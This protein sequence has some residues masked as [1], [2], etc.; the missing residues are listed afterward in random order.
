MEFTPHIK[1]LIKG[2]I[3]RHRLR[4]LIIAAASF[5]ALFTLVGFLIL[6]I[7]FKSILLKQ[8]SETLHGEV[9]I[10][11]VRVN[12][13]VLSLT[14][15]GLA[16]KDPKSPETLVS[17]DE[18]YINLQAKSAFK[19]ALILKEL[20]IK[21]PY[22]YVSRDKEGNINLL[23][24]LPDEETQKAPP[25]NDRNTKALT[26]E[27]DNIQLTG[28]K[29]LFSDFLKHS[30]F[31]TTVDSDLSINNFS[32]SKNKESTFV[33]TIKTEAN[34]TAKIDGKFSLDP[35]SSEGTFDLKKISLSKYSPYYRDSV[36]FDIKDGDLD[37]LANYTYKEKE[38]KI[39]LLLA[40]LISLQLKTR[41][42]KEEFLEI[43]IA[44]VKETEIDILKKQITLG[45]LTTKGGN[46]IVNRLQDGKLNLE[47]LVPASS[48]MEVKSEQNGNRQD[49]TPWCLTLKD[50]VAE[51]YTVKFQD[52]I[53][54]EPVAISMERIKL[55][56]QN[57]S[58]VEN[59]QGRVFLSL[60]LNKKG[61]VSAEGP[62]GINPVFAD[63][64]VNLKDIQMQPFEP[65]LREE[66]AIIVKE[67][68]ISTTSNLSL[69]YSETDGLKAT[70]QG[71]ASISNFSSMD[72]SKGN[73]F[74]K[75]ESLHLG[76]IDFGYNPS[77]LKI[78]EVA[79]TNFYSRLVINP[80]ATINILDIFEKDGQLKEE[81][82]EEM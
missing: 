64:K 39:S 35:L 71:E 8:L 63:V 66:V 78:N 82:Q 43:P 51:Q 58:T 67:G 69:S 6:P 34:E 81:N 30:E 18:T 46:L 62:F 33:L 15:K 32:T 7:I 49:T 29:V 25:E 36:L 60:R 16:I 72:K 13:Y 80:D 76:D 59:S 27:V 79:I 19:R 40:S 20:N 56:T 55:Q 77:Y 23:S 53:L 44:S 75:W 65:Y 12:P 41:N 1:S 2:L 21:H 10:E 3:E 42:E 38:A 22:L 14:V 73:D 11:K 31:Q 28:V 24:L 45:E 61:I 9:V 50:A 37:I 17:V 74:L 5:L 52:E 47:T 54:S 4:K 68:N 48:S 26:I 57:I 70:Y